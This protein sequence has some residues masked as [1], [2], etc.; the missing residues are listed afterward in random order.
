MT[1]ES[2][3]NVYINVQDKSSSPSTTTTVEPLHK[4]LFPSFAEKGPIGQPVY[5][6]GA[7]IARIF[8]QSLLDATG[9]Y[10]QTLNY[11]YIS[12][13]AS[14]QK[15]WFLRLDDN[16]DTLGFAL[17]AIANTVKQAPVYTRDAFNNITSTVQTDSSG[18]PVK[19]DQ[20]QYSFALYPVSSTNTLTPSAVASYF[21]QS[22]DTVKSSFYMLLSAVGTTPGNHMSR[23]AIALD[24]STPASDSA[25]IINAINAPLVRLYPRYCSDSSF[26]YLNAKMTNTNYTYDSVQSIYGNT[27]VDFCP[28]YEDITYGSTNQDYGWSSAIESAYTSV[29]NGW[30]LDYNISVNVYGG[31]PLDQ[32]GNAF[33]GTFALALRMYNDSAKITGATQISSLSQMTSAQYQ[34]LGSINPFTGQDVSGMG[35]LSQPFGTV[36]VNGASVTPSF[37][38]YAN[39]SA[40]DTT[41]MGKV[42]PVT[43]KNIDA[44]TARFFDASANHLQALA[45]PFAVPFNFMYDPGWD[46][47]TK[48]AVANIQDLRDDVKIDWS[49]ETLMTQGSTGAGLPSWMALQTPIRT[50]NTYAQT[51]SAIS[52]VAASVKGHGVDGEYG[53]HAFRG[54][55]F[56]Q[57]GYVNVTSNALVPLS[58]NYERL[59]QR[60]AYYSGPTV[61]GTPKGRPN[62]VLSSFNSLSW[63]PTSDDQKQVIWNY[64]AN[65][66]TYADTNVLFFPDLR[67]I[68]DDETSLLSSGTFADLIMFLKRIIRLQW[69]YFV[70]TEKPV[71]NQISEIERAIDTAAFQAFGTYMTTKTTVELQDANTE[72]DYTA[73][74]TTECRGNMSDRIWKV[75]LTPIQ[76]TVGTSTNS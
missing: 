71:Q 69:T 54:E 66:A 28:M 53:T 47:P 68:Y 26:S 3:P 8:G 46:F 39:M 23:N 45:D 21:G 70:G 13:T 38:K 32:R 12:K 51:M 63:V 34:E 10:S 42:T 33:N 24:V 59:R 50:P 9:P 4:P 20:T 43:D 41:A 48:S 58:T 17:F 29:S 75:V 11:A 74:I 25:K 56:P 61:K 15:F 40:F 64:G 16:S 52:A 60:L 72:N 30:L 22:T 57:A 7:T 1:N 36:S 44:A 18:N 6:D 65:Y 62:N 35:Y 27:Y 55:I 73:M 67:T 76:N 2:F 49:T 5:G 19:A 14:A 37:G 31:T